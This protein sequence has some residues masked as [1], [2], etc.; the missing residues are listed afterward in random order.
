M[1]LLA[2]CLLIAAV[3]FLVVAI[4]QDRARFRELEKRRNLERCESRHA[5]NFLELEIKILRYVHGHKRLPKNM[6]LVRGMN[7]NPDYTNPFSGNPAN[8]NDVTGLE[9]M[10]IIL[11]HDLTFEILAP[12]GP[13]SERCVIAL[14]DANGQVMCRRTIYA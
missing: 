6:D 3:V 10:R 12:E 1:S 4:F 7:M 14:N 9:E 11:P 8:V 13:G 2:A 5:Q